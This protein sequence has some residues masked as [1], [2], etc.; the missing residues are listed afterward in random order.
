M[1]TKCASTLNNNI[2]NRLMLDGHLTLANPSVLYILTLSNVSSSYDDP[3]W[4]TY[5]NEVHNS[6]LSVNA[7]TA[8]GG[9]YNATG[10]YLTILLSLSFA[11]FMTVNGNYTGYVSPQVWKTTGV[12]S[13]AYNLTPAYSAISS[14]PRAGYCYTW[15]DTLDPGMGIALRVN[16]ENV[17]MTAATIQD[18]RLYLQPLALT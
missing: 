3:T 15:M 5:T 11:S 4:L 1:F 7:G 8:Y 10:Y 14:Y 2:L 13:R 17:H 9:I 12:Y 6:F 18:A 16:K